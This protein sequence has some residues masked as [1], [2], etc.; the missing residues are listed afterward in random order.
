[1]AYIHSDEVHAAAL[2]SRSA[3]SLRA[4]L[5]TATAALSRRVRTIDRRDAV[6]L[7]I[8][9]AIHYALGIGFA[10]WV[11]QFVNGNMNIMN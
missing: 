4:R 11:I 6:R 5:A 9:T 10:I 7:A 2:A 1:M 3:A 8:G